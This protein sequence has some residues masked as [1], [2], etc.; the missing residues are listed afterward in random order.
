MYGK[1]SA[2]CDIFCWKLLKW[3][4]A[5]TSYRKLTVIDRKFYGYATTVSTMNIDGI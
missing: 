2:N 4:W 5:C 3:N 1:I